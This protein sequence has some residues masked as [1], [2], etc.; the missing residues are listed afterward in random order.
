MNVFNVMNFVR[1]CDER[2][3]NYREDLF[4]VTKKEL[5]LVNEFGIEN[6]FLLQY[7]ALCDERYVKLFKENTNDKTE[8]G[9]WLEIV[10]PMTSACGLPY[11]SEH[12]WK[13]D[14]HIIPGLPMGYNP[15][16]RRLLVD[17]T[18]RKFKEVFGYFPKTVGG[19]LIDTFTMNYFA[20]NYEID[21]FCIC[22]DQVNT[23]AYTLIGGYFNGAYYPSKNNIFTPAQTSKEQVNAPVF[24]LLGPC[25][26]HNYD[27]EK[28]LSKS[29][30]G[31]GNVYSLEPVW[32]MGKNKACVEWMYKTYFEN[33]SLGFSAL[34][35]GQENSFCESD[36]I[37]ALRTQLE[38]ACEY[39]KEGKA[40]FKKYCDTG[41]YFKEK[42][43]QT[44]ATSVVATDNWN[45]ADTQ[46]VYYQSKD[47]VAN[48]FRNDK[49]I[50]IRA[51]YLFDEKIEDYYTHEK[52]TRFDAIYENLPIVDTVIWQK[53]NQE[54]IGMVLD[55]DAE[56][57][58]CCKT[59]ENEITVCWKNKTVIF[60]ENK[61][62]ISGC[63]CIKYNLGKAQADVTVCDNNVN[64]CYKNN[65]YSLISKS[66]EVNKADNQLI[67]NGENITFE[68]RREKNELK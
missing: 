36:F 50:F 13:W 35:L 37:P 16:E 63:D 65:N 42:Y 40:V 43:T 6:T 60:K 10:E 64:F 3:P 51:L 9:I 44:P 47:Y 38:L 45:E 2:F 12:N 59:G 62:L 25:P 53:N 55:T 29:Q 39:V 67:F 4:N 46:S 54:N 17:E 34:Q 52:C 57:F 8:L 48:I 5:E 22:R 32:G 21:A 26:I 58:E 1:A 7:D 41:K 61:I 49:E 31:F 15:E 18:M 23:D 33:E 24:R 14:W 66:C 68:F 20:E 11:E 30:K 28:F 19:W 27:G 56:K